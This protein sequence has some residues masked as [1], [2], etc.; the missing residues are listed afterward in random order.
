MNNTIIRYNIKW[1]IDK[2]GYYANSKK[3]HG[4]ARRLH[5]YTYWLAYGVWSTPEMHI[6]HIDFNKLNN[7]LSNLELITA[8]EHK[9]K[10]SFH[11]VNWNKSEKG[12]EVRRRN[13]VNTPN[14][15]FKRVYTRQ[16]RIC[17]TIYESTKYKAYTCSRKC[18]LIHYNRKDNRKLKKC[19]Q[20]LS[21]FLGG[22]DKSTCSKE[23]ANSSRLSNKVYLTKTC[24]K[25]FCT[26]TTPKSTMKYCSEKC[27]I[28]VK[29][30]TPTS[31]VCGN[32][33]CCNFIYFKRSPSTAAGCS[34]KCSRR[35][36]YLKRTGRYT[37]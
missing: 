33:G 24:E 32:I 6:H 35:V 3:R 23:C 18:S 37:Y 10:H 7:D 11:L 30:G 13:Y 12:M 28:A 16:C 36:S 25:C 8:T 27:T 1:T 9:K 34:K 2:D 15:A 20:C 14:H 19:T 26:F 17:D 21:E 4:K 29:N 22:R 31:W 5:Q